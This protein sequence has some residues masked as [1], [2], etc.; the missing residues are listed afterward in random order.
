MVVTMKI[1]FVNGFYVPHLGG[2][3]TYTEKLATELKRLGHEIIIITSK[4]DDDLPSVEKGDFTIYRLPTRNIFKQRCPILLKNKEFEKL[5][6]EI[7]NEGIDFYICNARFYLTTLFGLKLA[8][9]NK[10]QSLVVDH[11]SGKVSI[12]NKVLDY[13]V[14]IYERILTNRVKK[15]TNNFYGVSKRCNEWLKHFGINARGVF[16]NSIDDSEYK[17]YKDRQFTNKN[18]SDVKILFV[19]RLLREKGVVM[20][21]DVFTDLLVEYKNIRLFIAGTGKIDD[22]LRKQYKNK[23][24]EFVGKLNHD[25]V[26]ALFNT[27]DIF[28]HPS[29]YPEGLPTVIG[30]AGLMKCAVI[31]TD[32]G[33]TVELIDSDEVGLIIE[34]TRMDLRDKLKFLINNPK[35][36]KMLSESLYNR[37]TKEF[38]WRKTVKV[39]ESTIKELMNEKN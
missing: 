10:K 9:R 19:G 27:A 26:M 21:L 6:N 18:K 14:A 2:V 3:E 16:Y 25:S 4:H 20:L 1:A 36:V 32:R 30:E 5:V 13:F 35:Q 8:K 31:A 17:K 15:Y 22:D 7:N 23:K 28:V 12:G 24:I 11:S 39:V 37:V 33:G 38:N 34:E 29:M